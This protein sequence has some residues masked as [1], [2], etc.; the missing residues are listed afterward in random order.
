MAGLSERCLVAARRGMVGNGSGL[1]YRV[2]RCSQTASRSQPPFLR[3]GWRE[4]VL[5]T[6]F[7][8]FCFHP[9]LNLF[10]GRF[11]LNGADAEFL[12]GVEATFLHR[13]NQSFLGVEAFG[14]HG[15]DPVCKGL[16]QFRRVGR[17]NDFAVNQ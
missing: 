4:V 3:A 17:G 5:V 2:K 9:S 7:N 16:F 1:V 13:L 10:E 14:G 15:A 12:T 6:R 11:K 8:F